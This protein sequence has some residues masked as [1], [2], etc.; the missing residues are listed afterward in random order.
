MIT[1]IIHHISV[2]Y[3][4]LVIN[5]KNDSHN[6]NTPDHSPVVTNYKLEA[7]LWQRDGVRHYVRKFVLFLI[8][9]GSKKSFK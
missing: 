4:P 7:L 9:Y 2:D 6:N 1:V 8:K 3:S 5:Y